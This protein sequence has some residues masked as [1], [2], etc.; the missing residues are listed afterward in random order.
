MSTL[1]VSGDDLARD[2]FRQVMGRFATGVTVLSGGG[3]HAHG[4]T[5]NAFTSVSLDPPLVLACVTR[6]ARLNTCIED[7]GSFGVSI[8]ADD[9]EPVARYFARSGRPVGMAQFDLFGWHRGP[10]SGTPLLA[11]AL[12]WLECEVVDTI[13]GGDHHVYLGRVLSCDCGPGTKP[14]AFFSGGYA[15][16]SRPTGAA[17]PVVLPVR[18]SRVGDIIDDLPAG[19][20]VARTV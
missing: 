10:R 19:G 18:G 5:A 2:R 17:R 6:T 16:L 7:T 13:P 1:P 3:P 4:M 15:A 9:Q 12:A 11:G 8:L 20:L 14:L